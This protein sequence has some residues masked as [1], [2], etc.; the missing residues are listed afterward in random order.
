MHKKGNIA[1][2]SVL[3]I[4]LVLFF[5]ISYT[6]SN[7]LTGFIIFNPEA[8]NLTFT[9]PTPADGNITTATQVTVRVTADAAIENAWL[10]WDGINESMQGANTNWHID[11][12]GTGQHT[13][14][15]HANDS[16]DNYD[17]TDT[18]TITLNVTTPV[19]VNHTLSQIPDQTTNED[20][21]FTLDVYNYLTTNQNALAYAV[22]ATP[23]TLATCTITSTSYVNCTLAQDQNGLLTITVNVSA[24]TTSAA[25]T[26]NLNITP[27]N[28]APSMIK[29]FTN[30][31]FLTTE[32]Y[33]INLTSYF[34]DAEQNDLT[35]GATV[36]TGLA[37]NVSSSTILLTATS[38]F[39]GNTTVTFTAND[40]INLA[41]SPQLSVFIL[42]ISTPE[43]PKEIAIPNQE[44]DKN[45]NLQLNLESYFAHA[46]TNIQYS[47][48]G[49]TH[50]AAT[51][52]GHVVTLTPEENWVGSETVTF[53]ATGSAGTFPGNQVSLTVRETQHAPALAS[54]LPHITFNQNQTNITINLN[55][56]FNDADS[57]PLTY[58][59]NIS[60]KDIK[61]TLEN[62]LLSLTLPKKTSQTEATVLIYAEDP[63]HQ[64][65]EGKITITIS[66]DMQRKPGRY[67]L[68]LLV[69][70]FALIAVLVGG[71][72]MKVRGTPALQPT[73]TPRQFIQS[74]FNTTPKSDK[75]RKE[76]LQAA[77]IASVLSTLTQ[78]C[79][80]RVARSSLGHQKD[81][82][83]KL[84]S[85]LEKEL[86]EDNYR[87][88]ILTLK[89]TRG[90][91]YEIK[92]VTKDD[93][94]KDELDTQIKAVETII[95]SLTAKNKN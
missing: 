68:A 14:R 45:T 62:G 10:E 35:Y 81:N 3:V 59:T 1:F 56:Y 89:E 41:A 83:H 37:A 38:G 15:V 52:N 73:Q 58:T 12:T 53:T 16:Q 74:V 39:I 70:T 44:W 72:Y 32:N 91:L 76:A 31:T 92:G 29:N 79:T 64:A 47:I 5:G 93:V 23:D 60:T 8:L 11:K 30:I 28:D 6:S 95:R 87:K 66:E 13:Y 2:I 43:P 77:E 36:G 86:D 42:G 65:A 26:F 27:V 18:R 57:E 48:S 7:P 63:A 34:H 71:G 80:D 84:R 85:L 54:E 4:F 22:S 94:L 90:A 25:S 21:T 51:F 20:S 55:D 49:L 40:S 78:H 46:G 24:A 82:L 9:D 67:N 19:S 33:T 69:A 88:S 50:I 75:Y 17:H 61:V